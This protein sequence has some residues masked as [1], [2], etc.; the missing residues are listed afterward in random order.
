MR[1]HD[2]CPWWDEPKRAEFVAAMGHAL[3]GHNIGPY[4]ID[5]DAGTVAI[6][7]TQTVYDLEAAARRCAGEPS[8]QWRD[9]LHVNIDWLEDRETA[10]QRRS[11]AFA[12]LE[13]FSRATTMA[14]ATRDLRVKIVPV[15]DLPAIEPVARWLPYGL[16]AAL[17]VDE[18]A[19]ATFV[20]RRHA[21]G[22]GR[23]NMAPSEGGA[24]FAWS[25]G[26]L[27]TLCEPE[28]RH[29]PSEDLVAS[30]DVYTGGSY[31]TTLALDVDEHLYPNSVGTVVAIPAA[32]TVLALHVC[33]NDR[34]LPRSLGAMAAESYARHRGAEAPVSPHLM[35]STADQPLSE[36]ARIS[37][38]AVQVD[39]PAEVVGLMGSGTEEPELAAAYQGLEL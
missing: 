1:E 31:A 15:V 13:V 12:E 26:W 7:S 10:Q 22:W 35:W 27:N 6:A 28:P 3:L 34:D 9:L 18:G 14:E 21:A 20:D 19:A 29:N 37:E 4:E 30:H 25:V 23:P 16:A 36:L 8:D 33:S 5:P 24:A 32:G 11:A 17:V 38:N 39:V 2:W